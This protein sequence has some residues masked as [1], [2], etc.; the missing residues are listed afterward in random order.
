MLTVYTSFSNP[1][2]LGFNIQIR[3]LNDY[4]TGLVAVRQRQTEE[5]PVGLKFR[6]TN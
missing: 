4:K 1:T 5:S 3:D 6:Q 2:I